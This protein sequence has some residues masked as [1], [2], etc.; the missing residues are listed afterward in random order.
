MPD[1]YAFTPAKTYHIIFIMVYFIENLK[2]NFDFFL[3]NPFSRKNYYEKPEDLSNVFENKDEENYYEDLKE[4]YGC[5]LAKN[6]TERRFLED[7]YFL[8]IF[9]KCLGKTQKDN[10]SV[11]DIGSKIW[12]YVKSEHIFFNSFCENVCL[13]GI[14]LDAYRLL[15]NFYTRC[16]VAKFYTKNLKNTHYIASDLMLHSGKYDY[17]IW[18]LPFITKYPLV[19]WGL[20]LRYFKPLEMLEYAY[21]LLNQNGELLIINQG[22]EEYKIQQELYKNLNLSPILYDEIQDKFDLFKNKRYCSKIVKQ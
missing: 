8:H 2:N 22:E 1:K 7:I 6:T 21:N 20:P 3:R 18:I 11:L 16:E 13:N 17:I 5:E 14:E 15:S 4:K 19:K 12:S 10:M 9:D